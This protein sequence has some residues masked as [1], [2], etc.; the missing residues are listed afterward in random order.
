MA[1]RGGG[2][3]GQQPHQLSRA[4]AAEACACA[5]AV[6]PLKAGCRPGTG[7]TH[8]LFLWPG[9]QKGSCR[10]C[11]LPWLSHLSSLQTGKLRNCATCSGLTNN[12][13]PFLPSQP[14]FFCEGEKC[15]PS[16]FS[17]AQSP[18]LQRQ[19]QAFLPGVRKGWLVHISDREIHALYFL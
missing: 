8:A 19:P 1:E 18:M 6:R 2:G 13:F 16:Q 9:S 15:A 4:P 12:R 5:C 17:E 11:S 7:T 3:A 10:W 14:D